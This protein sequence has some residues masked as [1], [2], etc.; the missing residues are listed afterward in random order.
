MKFVAEIG[1]NHNGDVEVARK[2]VDVAAR[3]KCDHVKIQKRNVSECYSPEE[4]AAPCESPWGTTVGDKV[5]GRELRW[6]QIQD[7]ARYASSFGLG[8]TVSCFDRTSQRELEEALP[9]RPFNKVPSCMCVLPDLSV[10]RE[11]LA[12]VADQR[13]LTLISTGLLDYDGIDVAARIFEER[14]CCYVLLH[15]VAL[16]PAPPERLEL[17]AIERMR[18]RYL[19]PVSHG[20]EFPHC[21]AIGYSGHEVGLSTT[22]GAV[23]LGAEWVERHVTLDRSMYGA[24]Q[25]ASVE[26]QGV[27]TLVRD[28]R[29]HEAA[30]GSGEKRLRG[31]EKV[32]V[33]RKT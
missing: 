30:Y 25:A 6:D 1:I 3:C 26:E 4:L 15:C 17:R 22:L 18:S 11:F 14:D 31:D 9:D 12:Q 2:L 24:D 21:Q 29:K 19:V 32:P 16:Y 23:A 7:L 10:N 28:I 13:R 27:R 5:R 33:R 20:G 8:L